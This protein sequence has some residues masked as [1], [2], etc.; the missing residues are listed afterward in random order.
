MP[1]PGEVLWL[2][3]DRAWALALAEVEADTCKG[4]GQPLSQSMRGENEFKY[5]GE[6]L[7]CHGCVGAAIAVQ[8]RAD[9]AGGDIRGLY[10]HTHLTN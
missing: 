6:V 8:Q 10:V 4:C 3:E 1:G 7:T 2:P 5:R 9:Q